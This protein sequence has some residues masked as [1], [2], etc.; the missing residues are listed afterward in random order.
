MF[1]SIC[2][3][4]ELGIIAKNQEIAKILDNWKIFDTRK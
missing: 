2:F 4:A 1:H 3:V